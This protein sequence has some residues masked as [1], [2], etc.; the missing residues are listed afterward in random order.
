MVVE[1]AEATMPRLRLL[2]FRQPQCPNRWRLKRKLAVGVLAAQFP[3]ACRNR[4]NRYPLASSIS[5]LYT[6]L[7]PM[8]GADCLRLD[9]PQGRIIEIRRQL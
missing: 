8:T 4:R 7:A 3:A 6:I 1:P 2:A 9:W 5:I